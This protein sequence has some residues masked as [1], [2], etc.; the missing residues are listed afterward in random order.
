MPQSSTLANL[1]GHNDGAG[2]CWHLK[3]NVSISPAMLAMLFGGLGLVTLIIGSAFYWVGASLIL[4]FSIVEVVALLVA[5]FYNAVHANDY[6]RLTLTDSTI[7]IESKIGF[8][9]RQVQLLRSMT[10]VDSEV[11]KNQLIQL[12]QGK[13]TT[14]FGQ[15][16][17]ANLRPELAQQISHRLLA[18]FHTK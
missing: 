15:F 17:H 7:E 9:T 14:F 10:R 3:R 12:R 2:W 4:P 18:R 1:Q 13:Q 16:V 5:Y 6:E 8:H 11:H